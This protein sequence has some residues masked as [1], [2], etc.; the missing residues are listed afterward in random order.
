MNLQG[1]LYFW[2]DTSKKTS[3]EFTK[4]CE[5]S[6]KSRGILACFIT[7][8]TFCS[9]YPYHS[10]TNK[11]GNFKML[12]KITKKNRGILA[13]LITACTFCSPSHEQYYIITNSLLSSSVR[14]LMLNA[15]MLNPLNFISNVYVGCEQYGC[16]REGI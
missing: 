7:A 9:S 2:G 13:C 3:Q 6:G 5:K 10:I 12:W 8:C 15:L 14:A 4:C 11:S 16:M 1:Y